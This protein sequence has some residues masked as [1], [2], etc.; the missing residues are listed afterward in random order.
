MNPS[1]LLQFWSVALLLALTPGADWAYAIAAGVRSRSV[2]PSI[3]GMVVGYAVV[4]TVVAAGVGTLVTAVPPIRTALMLA[5]GSYLV[6]LGVTTLLARHT[7]VAASDADLG[8]GRVAQF[9]RGAGVSGINPK[10][11]LLLIALLP[12]FIAPGGWPAPAQMATLGALHVLDCAVVYSVGALS[13]RRI[14][15]AKPR[16]AIVVTRVSGILM[17]A[18]GVAILV[19]QLTGTAVPTR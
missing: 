17:T 3:L 2:A 15:R 5:G 13:A 8:D 16:A 10:G 19:E 18:I 11:V 9:L 1:L 7:A 4:V 6:F 12:Q 14:V